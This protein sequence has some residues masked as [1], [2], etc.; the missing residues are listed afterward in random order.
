MRNATQK[1]LANIFTTEEL[2][3]TLLILKTREAEL[4]LK[5]SKIRVAVDAINRGKFNE[6]PPSIREEFN[7]QTEDFTS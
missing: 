6:I 2:A 5:L 4:N 7:L 3:S 1:Y